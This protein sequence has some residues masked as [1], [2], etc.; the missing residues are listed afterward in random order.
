MRILASSLPLCKDGFCSQNYSL[1]ESALVIFSCYGSGRPAIMVHPDRNNT[2]SSCL[3]IFVEGN[4]GCD[5]VCCSYS[6]CDLYF[7]ID[8][9]PLPHWSQSLTMAF[10]PVRPV[11]CDNSRG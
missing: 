5:S 11:E 2:R 1:P 7:V 6:P 3:V 9:K 8:L 4:S 10:G